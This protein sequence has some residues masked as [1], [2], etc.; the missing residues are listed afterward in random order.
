MKAT[1]T[2]PETYQLD[3]TLDFKT[4]RVKWT[5]NL[6][7]GALSIVFAWLAMQL[8]YW[9]HPSAELRAIISLQTLPL[10]IGAMLLLTL[11][12][13]VLHELVHGL[14]FWRFTGDRPKF[15]VTLSPLAFYAGAP[16]WYLPRH[17]HMIVGLAPLI[18]ITLAGVGLAIVL[19]TIPA[20]AAL[21]IA[22]ANAA[23]AIGDIMGFLWELR[24]P[25]STLVQ[26]SGDV[27]E[28]YVAAAG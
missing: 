11:V 15:G 4:G 24:L 17:Q 10:V 12:T 6:A 13:L 26:D 19:P 18:I 27:F 1:Q 16:D 21:F 25:A 2:L 5:M 3:R 23:G 28:S 9:L 8:L 7:G 22:T 20:A 14:F